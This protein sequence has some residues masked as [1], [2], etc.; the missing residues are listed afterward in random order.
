MQHN[1]KNMIKQLTSN[2][3]NVA[4]QFKDNTY[5]ENRIICEDGS[6]NFAVG[7]INVTG[8]LNVGMII[9]SASLIGAKEFYTFGRKRIDMRSTV[10]GE[11]YLPIKQY[12]YEDPLDA[13]K[14]LLD[15]LLTL[16]YTVVLV[17]HT[18]ENYRLGKNNA[19]I[20]S[21]CARPPLFLFGSESHG[22]PDTLL[23][24]MEPDGPEHL[25]H[26]LSIPQR[27]VL[28][29]F[30]VAAAATLVMWDYVKE[31]CLV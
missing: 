4:D 11:K 29:S 12:V 28:R 27:G 5:E 26:R 25:F 10:G 2:H 13:D 9:R 15:D 3:Y 18:N 17:E 16:P 30:N 24:A 20:Y 6:L 19:H 22:I 1:Y 21:M 31:R 8:E 23:N 14:Q 7:V